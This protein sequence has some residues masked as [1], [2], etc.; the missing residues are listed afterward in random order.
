MTPTSR[1]VP[2]G[3]S[4]HPVLAPHWLV[5]AP[6]CRVAVLEALQQRM[7]RMPRHSAPRLP[8]P[9]PR[10]PPRRWACGRCLTAATRPLLRSGYSRWGG[11]IIAPLGV[12]AGRR[13]RARRPLHAWPFRRAGEHF[14]CTDPVWPESAAPRR[15]RAAGRRRTIIMAS[16]AAWAQTARGARMAQGRAGAAWPPQRAPPLFRA[17]PARLPWPLLLTL[18]TTPGSSTTTPR[19]PDTQ[20]GAG[21]P[22]KICRSARGAATHCTATPLS[23]S[24]Q[25]M[26][27]L[28]R[29]GGGGGG[30]ERQPRQKQPDV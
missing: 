28:H 26:P 24:L 9:S 1:P 23:H 10:P 12:A 30:G 11:A 14:F 19:P 6:R 5:A 18:V 15:P 29:D 3:A 2:S 21:G 27:A 20:E 8:A 7:P 16:A 13:P 25:L 17:R 22:Q 4:L